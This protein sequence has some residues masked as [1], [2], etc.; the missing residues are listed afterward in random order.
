LD[1]SPAVS[2]PASCTSVH[3][4]RT[5]TFTPR[6]GLPQSA[7]GERKDAQGRR[8]RAFRFPCT[9]HALLTGTVPCEL[10]YRR[11]WRRADAY[12]RGSHHDLATTLNALLTT[13]VHREGDACTR[14]GAPC[15][16][17]CCREVQCL[18]PRQFA[19]IPNPTRVHSAAASTDGRLSPSTT[20]VTVAQ[21]AVQALAW[22]FQSGD[23]LVGFSLHQS[24]RPS[25]D[26]GVAR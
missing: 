5:T 25:A 11:S 15:G 26:S 23:T 7:A 20:R 16:V 3:L 2:L 12:H 13:P 14:R 10:V 6:R 4:T 17:H 21:R 1:Q 24:G 8:R 9:A 18:G 22:L 19:L